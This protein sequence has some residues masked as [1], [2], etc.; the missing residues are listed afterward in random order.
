M[1]HR[2]ARTQAPGRQKRAEKIIQ[3]RYSLR[4]TMPLQLARANRRHPRN[5]ESRPTI[6]LLPAININELRSAIPCYPGQVTEANVRL[7]CPDIA[8]LRLL[9]SHIEITGRNGY[10]QRFRLEW[11]RTGFGRHRPILGAIAAIAV[12]FVYSAVMAITPVAIVSEHSTHHRKTI[13]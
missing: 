10:V 8:R 9:A 3:R 12:L 6:E 2:R 4:M 13:K 7:K 5:S 1:T 11:I